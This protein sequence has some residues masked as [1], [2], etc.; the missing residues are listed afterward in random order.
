MYRNQFSVL[1]SRVAGRGPLTGSAG[2]TEVGLRRD[3]T[4]VRKSAS[5]EW[6]RA[7]RGRKVKTRRD[8]RSFE[9]EYT[10]TLDRRTT[11]ES[12]ERLGVKDPDVF[13]RGS[14]E[15]RMEPVTL[16]DFSDLLVVGSRTQ[17]PVSR[18]PCFAPTRTRDHRIG[19]S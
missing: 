13:P 7:R 14:G 19:S 9:K 8:G 15:G 1:V 17:P 3:K 5:N 18:E 2:A 16:Q 10:S 12:R 11:K 6:W 4:N